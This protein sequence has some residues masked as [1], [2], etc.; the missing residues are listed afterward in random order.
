MTHPPTVEQILRE[1]LRLE[2]ELR[3]AGEAFT[4]RVRQVLDRTVRVRCVGMDPDAGPIGGHVICCDFNHGARSGA[5]FARVVDWLV[6]DG[7]PSLVLERPQQILYVDVRRAFRVPTAGVA[8]LALVENAEQSCGGRVVDISRVGLCLD[9]AGQ[10]LIRGD[11][12]GLR[13]E[14]RRRVVQVTARVAMAG[15][16]RVGL[17]LTDPPEDYLELVNELERDWVRRNRE[18]SL[19]ASRRSQG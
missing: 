2:T 18:A 13:L 10:R 17:C 9:A 14:H 4:G 12:V 3:F 7:E 19:A 11:Y 16:D 8:L 1:C 15:L 6:C 5:F